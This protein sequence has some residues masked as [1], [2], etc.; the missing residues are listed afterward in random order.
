MEWKGINAFNICVLN[1]GG[2]QRCIC[3]GKRSKDHSF[4]A[5]WIGY[6]DREPRKG[7]PGESTQSGLH[8]PVGSYL[9]RPE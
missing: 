3:L 8:Y 9:T 2:I 6:L 1:G 7:A 5:I 4:L